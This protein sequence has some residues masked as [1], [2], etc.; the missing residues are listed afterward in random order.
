MWKRFKEG[1]AMRIGRPS[2]VL[3]FV[4]AALAATAFAAS[5]GVKQDWNEAQIRWMPYAAGMEEAKKTNKPVCLIFFTTWCPHCTNYSK[6]FSNPELVK[7]SQSFVMIR[8]DKDKNWDLSK[9]YNLDGEYIPRTYFL[10]ATGK[11]DPVLQETRDPYKYFYDEENPRSI[12]AGMD[13]ALKKFR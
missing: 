7:K 10:S 11:I 1:T 4:A 13:R 6:L 12:L 2:I 9:Q 3:L 5:A 8:I